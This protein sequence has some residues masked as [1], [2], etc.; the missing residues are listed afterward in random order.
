M[1]NL[2]LQLT[3]L[4]WGQYISNW[5][6]QFWANRTMLYWTS[7]MCS[8]EVGPQHLLPLLLLY[9][10]S[11]LVWWPYWKQITAVWTFP[12]SRDKQGFSLWR[13]EHSLPMLPEA[14]RGAEFVVVVLER[15]FARHVAATHPA[16]TVN[17]RH[18]LCHHSSQRRQINNQLTV[19]VGRCWSKVMAAQF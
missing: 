14:R 19:T 5:N 1:W 8:A 9:I 18:N 2:T 10:N 17:T 12:Q 13:R 6:N 4:Q 3:L 15:N 16:A 11:A 7:Y